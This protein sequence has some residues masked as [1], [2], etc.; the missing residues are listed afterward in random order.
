MSIVARNVAAVSRFAHRGRFALVLDLDDTVLWRSRG[1]FDLLLL[2]ANPFPVG[3]VGV[4]YTYAIEAIQALAERFDIAAVTSRSGG[5]AAHTER[6]LNAAGLGGMP[7]IHAAGPHPGDASRDA[8]KA[9]SIRHLRDIGGLNPV[10]GV[11]DRPSDGRA[12]RAEG[13]HSLVL[14]HGKVTSVFGGGVS[15][16]AAVRARKA[17]S[18]SA[19]STPLPK[20]SEA[21]RGGS[22]R[23]FTS[24]VGDGTICARQVLDQPATVLFTDE[25]DCFRWAAAAAKVPAR[26]ALQDSA[27]NGRHETMNHFLRLTNAGLVDPLYLHVPQPQS[28]ASPDGVASRLRDA[29]DRKTPQPTLVERLAD[30]LPPIWAQLRAFLLAEDAVKVLTS[31]SDS[32]RMPGIEHTRGSDWEEEASAEAFVRGTP[33]ATLRPGTA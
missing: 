22:L 24:V 18:A 29:V 8:F 23:P 25:P 26:E 30:Q 12:Y 31:L 9:A 13:L 27:A 28:E 33:R 15:G 14:A 16:S 1:A 3:S 11:G 7:L 4:P 20:Q 6:W 32:N 2:Y 21:G 17:C 5:A 10:I 19:S